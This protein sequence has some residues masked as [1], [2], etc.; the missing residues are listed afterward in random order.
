MAA[1]R[2]VV[3]GAG[4]AGAT[5]AQTL[6]DEGFDGAVVLVGEEPVRPYERPPLSKEYLQGKA[7]RDTVFVHPEHWYDDNTVELRT[8][9]AATAIDRRSRAVA[10]AD[11][12]R[13]PYDH[14]ILA[15]GSTPRRLDVPGATLAGVRYLRR[16]PDSDQL[17]DAFG[18]LPRVVVIGGGWIGLETAAAARVAG[19]EVTVLEAA[20]VPLGRVLGPDLAQVFADLHR[21]HG[22]DLRCGVEVAAI[23]GDH[24]QV[25]DVVLRD[26]SRVAAD[27]VIVGVGVTPATGLAEEAGLDV[28]N[29]ITVDEVLRTSDPA[30]LAAGDVANAYHPLFQRHL[31]V[32]HWANARRQGSAAARSVLGNQDGFARLPYFFTDQYD[33]SMEYVGYADPAEVHDIVVRGDIG[34]REFVAFWRVEGRV[35]AGMS[36]NVPDA[37]PAV[38]TLIT[39]GGRP[40]LALLADPDVPLSGVT[41]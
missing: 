13:L 40:D 35:T 15:T 17:K 26:G 32:E 29:G 19:L 23:T 12:E 27:L 10:L 4:L 22:V 33:L 37:V 38:E 14:L 25:S 8:G 36:V 24:G 16:L 21:D 2:V 18:Q 20:D 6:R 39:S 5:A 28:T 11:G 31:R 9:A 7:E 3:V 41:G 34:R 1:N 30:V